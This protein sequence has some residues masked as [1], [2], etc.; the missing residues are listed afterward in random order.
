[1]EQKIK[2][3]LKRIEEE[4][5][6]KV[7]FAAEAGSRAYELNSAESDYDIGFVFYRP[8]EDYISINKPN[9]QINCGFDKEFKPNRKDG[10]FIEMTG[11]DIFKYFQLLTSCNVASI[12]LLNSLI[13]YF[14]NITEL[15]DYVENNFN[16]AKLFTQYFISAKGIYKSHTASKKMN[17]KKYLHVMR[18]ILEAEYVLKYKKLPSTSMI[19]NLDELEKDLP[20]EVVQKIRELIVLKTTGHGKEDAKELPVLDNYFKETFERYRNLGIEAKIKDEKP[21]ELNFF[22]QLLQKLVMKKEK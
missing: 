13:V 10:V 18:V 22:N 21:M 12:D 9:E 4:K 14:G 8:L 5:K 7:L 3:L 2:E 16:R 15:K 17:I 20:S 19:K 11:H 1:M 6:I